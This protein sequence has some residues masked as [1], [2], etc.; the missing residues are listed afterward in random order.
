MWDTPTV[1]VNAA[2]TDIASSIDG[3]TEL[4]TP[5]AT[6]AGGLV[7]KIKFNVS[8]PTLNINNNIN[9]ENKKDDGED[10]LNCFIIGIIGC[11]YF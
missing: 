5:E 4:S 9:N 3:N 10:L 8:K 6:P 2:E 1:S 11:M 7:T